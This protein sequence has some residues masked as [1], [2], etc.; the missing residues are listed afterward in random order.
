MNELDQLPEIQMQKLFPF[1][2]TPHCR[3]CG[4]R[5]ASLLNWLLRRQMARFVTVHCRGG[6][7]PSEEKTGP[8][9]FITLHRDNSCAGLHKEHLHRQCSRCGYEWLMEIFS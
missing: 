8:L 3:K 9:P 4:A 6:K 5:S 2:E 7:P 1:E